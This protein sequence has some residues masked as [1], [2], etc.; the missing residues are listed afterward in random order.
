YDALTHA[1]AAR[2]AVGNSASDLHTWNVADGCRVYPTRS[3]SWLRERGWRGGK[4]PLGA[5]RWTSTPGRSPAPWTRSEV[6]AMRIE[7]A[8]GHSFAA[9]L[10]LGAAAA[11]VEPA[12]LGGGE[13]L[14]GDG[15]NGLSENAGSDAVQG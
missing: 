1:S 15:R 4:L 8:T 14:V 6:A 2:R 13:G 10:A 11:L 7:N 3:D 9:L 5:V 12:C